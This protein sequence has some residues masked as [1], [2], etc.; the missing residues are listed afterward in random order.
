MVNVFLSH[1]K[2]LL[3]TH[4]LAKMKMITT[5]GTEIIQR[6]LVGLLVSPSTLT[7]Q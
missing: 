1:S 4:D 5:I 3:Y 2:I 6:R 7:L